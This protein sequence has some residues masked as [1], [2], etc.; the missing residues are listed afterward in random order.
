MQTSGF[1]FCKTKSIC[2]TFS[3][4]E[5]HQVYSICHDLKEPIET[6]CETQYLASEIEVLIQ[7]KHL[8]GQLKNCLAESIKNEINSFCRNLNKTGKCK[9]SV[10]NY[11][12]G[13]EDCYV[14]SKNIHF[15]YTIYIYFIIKITIHLM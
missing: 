4:N 13:Y 2:Y 15:I 3:S 11:T 7:P 6:E 9:F 5:G 14:S 8:T 10:L 12:S 1:F